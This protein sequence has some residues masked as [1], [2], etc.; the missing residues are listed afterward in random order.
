MCRQASFAACWT[1]A[2]SC[3]RKLARAANALKSL[4]SL[5][6]SSSF[7]WRVAHILHH[8]LDRGLLQPVGDREQPN[9]FHELPDVFRVGLVRDLIVLPTEPP[10]EGRRL[11]L[12]S[13]R[14]TKDPLGL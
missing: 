12:V 5:G 4:A 10:V 2:L 11:A 1:S 6:S 13:P 8:L 9:A 3:E 7:Q 14:S